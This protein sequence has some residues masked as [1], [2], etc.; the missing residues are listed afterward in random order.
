MDYFLFKLRLETAVHFGLSDAA[1]SLAA[2]E[3]HV[4]AD[5]LFSALCQTALCLYGPEGVEELCGQVQEGKL[6]L[7]DT[8]PWRGD[9]LFLP[10]PVTPVETEQD[11]PSDQK[12]KR[13]KQRW[14]PVSAWKDYATALQ[15]SS[16]VPEQ[17]CCTRF[18]RHME[19]TKAATP[20]GSDA[21]PYQVGL[22]QY[23]GTCGEEKREECQHCPNARSCCGLY[24]LCACQPEQIDRL[25]KL[26]SA[27]GLSGLGGKTSAG[28]GK[29]RIA[30]EEERPVALEGSQELQSLGRSL[31]AQKGPY[32]LLTTSLPEEEELEG[33][34]KDGDFRLIRR[35]GF[36]QAELS[37]AMKKR[38]QYFLSAGAVLQAPFQGAL[39]QVGHTGAHPVYRYGRPLLLGVAE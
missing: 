21:Q 38:S 26:V 32:L 33:A 39:Y 19:W 34:L 29:F 10:K 4:R 31:A 6:L 5:T 2:S 9:T 13:K 36:V 3:E 24:F 1:L 20:Q 35:S 7:S 25:T 17:A 23:K 37:T 18:G 8:M 12:K 28:F 22:F 16:S 14:I 11:L 15:S 30:G 27:L